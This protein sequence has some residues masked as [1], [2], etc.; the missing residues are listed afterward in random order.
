MEE[1]ESARLSVNSGYQEDGETIMPLLI[2]TLNNIFS[3]DV[4]QYD[5]AYT[6]SFNVSE[7]PW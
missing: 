5:S 6:R 4:S 2:K 3:N 7:V 1:W